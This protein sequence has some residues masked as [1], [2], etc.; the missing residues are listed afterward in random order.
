MLLIKFHSFFA[1][2]S[3]FC[4]GICA[5]R[6]GKNKRKHKKAAEGTFG[7]WMDVK[8]RKITII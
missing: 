7:G 2:C 1:G 6:I 5:F 8:K 3:A 4:A